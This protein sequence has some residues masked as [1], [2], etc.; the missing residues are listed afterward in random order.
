MKSTWAKGHSF[1]VLVF[2]FSLPFYVLAPLSSTFIPEGLPINHL[3]FLMIIVPI[4]AAFILTYKKGGF[5]AAKTALKKPL[6]YKKIP[7]KI[8]VS[9][10]RE[11]KCPIADL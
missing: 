4:T 2:L 11:I 7:L 10:P 1:F 8:L 9:C 6:D 3:D 5:T